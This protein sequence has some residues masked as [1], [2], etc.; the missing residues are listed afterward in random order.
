[1]LLRCWLEWGEK[2]LLRIEGDFAFA[3]FDGHERSLVLARDTAGER[4]LHYYR[5]PD[6]F[7]FASM[8]QPLASL[9]PAGCG[10]NAARLAE[11]VS[12]LP[13]GGSQSFFDQVSRVEPGHL[14]RVRFGEI[15]SR[16]YWKPDFTP[17]RL[18][19]P[20]QYGEA[21]REEIDRA[22]VRRLRRAEGKVAAHLSAGFD[23]SAVASSA[24]LQLARSNEEL[25]AF[26]AAP[27]AGP[28]AAAPSGR[29]ADESPIAGA[30]ARLHPN[31]RHAI[32]RAEASPLERLA[33]SHELAGQ[34]VG[35][36]F[37][38]VW[39]QAIDEAAMNRG[40]TVMLTAEMGNFS[41]ST[42]R[43]LGPLG[44]LLRTFRWRG[45]WHEARLL[46]DRDYDW[47]NIAD[48]SLGP[49][50][51]EPVY[52][53]LRRRLRPSPLQAGTSE[54]LA[55]SWCRHATR[56]HRAS[57]WEVR[58]PLNSSRRRWSLMKMAD[59]GNYRK[60]A[61]A[62]WGVEERD[63]TADRRLVQFCFSLP[64]EALLKDGRDRPALRQAIAGRVAD[65]VLTGRDR[66]YQSADWYRQLAP[67][68][69]CRFLKQT[70]G[71][72]EVVNIRAIEQALCEWPATAAENRD[73]I[74]R[75]GM[76]LTRAISALD[77]AARFARGSQ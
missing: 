69:I 73:V 26:T 21:L 57:G 33:E 4:P 66:G 62:R 63:P 2:C 20:A 7:A 11:F 55:E 49:F 28:N 35:S 3:L 12:D 44:D 18:P 47:G 15:E 16:R 67:D 1:L 76:S 30:T 52:R 61:L 38:H 53:F 68:E 59:P 14:L 9:D 75:F 24:A 77:F 50:L 60:A 5:R 41:I 36:V 43:G 74:Y 27:F 29:F 42:G 46:T 17:L 40:A 54:F 65:T 19:S 58:P 51:P 6:L 39:W 64:P 13:I 34:P 22:V 71:H 37:N 8:P 56:A 32:I 23:S 45:W 10:P 31:I 48:A 25:L 72:D 70:R